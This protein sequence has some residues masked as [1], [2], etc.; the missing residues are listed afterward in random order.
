M[1]GLKVPVF[2]WNE[3]EFVVGPSG[4]VETVDESAAVGE[5][6]QKAQATE[7]GTYTVYYDAD[8]QDLSHKYGSDVM[9]VLRSKDL[10]EA[11]RV[12][13][14]ER[15]V[16]EAILF[17]PWIVEVTDIVIVSLGAGEYSVTYTIESVFDDLITQGVTV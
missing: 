3:N 16:R 4:A 1:A 5:L 17:D 7:R 13:E 12:S 8:N 9:E 10:T 15:T 11:S 14:L 6:S 2:N